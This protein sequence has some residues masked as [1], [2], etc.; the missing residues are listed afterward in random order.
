MRKSI[1]LALVSGVCLLVGPPAVQAR[2]DGSSAES[3]VRTTFTAFPARVLQGKEV[4]VSIATRAGA[5][6][7]LS[8][9]YAGGER[10][11]GLARAYAT[12][13]RAAWRWTVPEEVKAGPARVTASC[14]RGGTATR[15][16]IVVGA[17]VPPK[18]AVEQQGFSVR[19]RVTGS[20]VVSYGLMLRNLSSNVDALN[21]NILVNFV[22]ANDRVIGT[23]A[24]NVAA[25]PAA[26]T[27]A[28]GGSLSFP[29]GAPVER[30]EVVIQ[31]A[32]RQKSAIHQ[33]ALAGVRVVP[34]VFEPAWL[35][36]VEGE[37]IN[38][39]PTL[40]LRNTQLWA[41]V[42]DAA[43]NIV[44]GGSGSAFPTL[45]PGT[46]QAFKVISGV[47]AVPILNAAYAQVSALGTYGPVGT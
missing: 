28:Y 47:S 46:R 4:A 1:A 36:S 26:K 45:P 5:S 42:F 3:A 7:Q 32:G 24:H 33:P 15:S 22:M 8:V 23:D 39:H 44:G 18:I 9:G 17:L 14:T 12:G 31:V 20:S 43:G 25:L 16:F 30:L 40:A 19:N 34:S 11:V 41:V 10:Q 6:C 27:F 38:D 35:G 2:T 29:A 21:V 13:G 37:V